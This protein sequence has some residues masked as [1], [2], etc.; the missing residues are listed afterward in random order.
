MHKF[1]LFGFSQKSFYMRASAKE[2]FFWK[3]NVNKTYGSADQNIAEKV[4]ANHNSAD[5]NKG[6]E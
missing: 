3:N 4:G 6:G 2:K 5:G 1:N